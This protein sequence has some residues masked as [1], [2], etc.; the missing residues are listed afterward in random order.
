VL[1]RK[2][3]DELCHGRRLHAG[4]V[5]HETRAQGRRLTIHADQHGILLEHHSRH[6]AAAGERGAVRFRVREQRQH[7]GVTIDDAGL[8]RMERR[9]ARE[10]GLERTHLRTLQPFGLDAV[11]TR[12]GRE[13]PEGRQLRVIGD[14]ELAAAPMG[15]APLAA[16]VVQALAARNA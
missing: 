1:R 13:A 14:D 12:V 3:L 9:R 4:A 7:Q 5:D 8:G 2:T 16:K 11:G 10:P 6:R 15:D